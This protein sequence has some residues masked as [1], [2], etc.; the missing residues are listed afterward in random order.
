MEAGD[1][2][3]AGRDVLKWRGGV[4]NDVSLALQRGF[5]AR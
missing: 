5:E 2:E 4:K 1:I 3:R